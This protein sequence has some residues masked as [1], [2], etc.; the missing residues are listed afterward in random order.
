MYGN[1]SVRGRNNLAT[2][3][4]SLLEVGCSLGERPVLIGDGSFLMDMNS[5]L[6]SRGTTSIWAWKRHMADVIVTSMAY[7]NV[8]LMHAMRSL[9]PNHK[10]SF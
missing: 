9:E 5:P 10:L 8:G 7:A 4:R 1:F 2:Q 3:I 6:H